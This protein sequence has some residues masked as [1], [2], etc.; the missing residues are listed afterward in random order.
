[1]KRAII[2]DLDNTIYPVSS[3]SA[4]LF[5]KVYDLLEE[6]LPVGDIEAV[7]EDMGCRPYHLVADKFNFSDD[8]KAKGINILKN[9]TYDLPMQPFDD[10]HQ[11]KST[12][13]KKFL[14]TTGFSKL[15]WSKVK[16]LGIEDDFIEIHIV[17]PEISNQTK[18]DVFADILKRHNYTAADVLV[19]G[20]DPESEIKAA[21]ELGIDTFLFDPW[22][23]HVD[24]VVTYRAVELRDVLNYL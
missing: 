16:M 10:Y 18:K 9:I 22:D 14:V 1:M 4:N 19:T 17:D 13:I 6:H 2:L 24:A 7:K 20:D 12:Q 3:I 5:E 8:L 15:Q 11:V 23:K 21:T